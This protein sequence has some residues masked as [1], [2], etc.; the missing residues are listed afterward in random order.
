MSVMPERNRPATN[1]DLIRRYRLE[2]LKTDRKK[3][4]TIIAANENQYAIIKAYV[5]DVTKYKNQE[6]FQTTWFFD[7]V[8]T[9]E[10]EPFVSMDEPQHNIGDLY[11]DRLTGN[12]YILNYD[13]DNDEYSWGSIN[14]DSLKNSLS[15]ANSDVDTSDNKR[16][17]F[18]VQPEPLYEAGDIWMDGNTIMRCKCTR[19]DGEFNTLDWTEQS[20]YSDEY[21][22]VGVKAELDSF[23]GEVR[24][25]YATQAQLRTTKESIEG[26]VED[27]TNRVTELENSTFE[28]EITNRVE[29]IQTSTYTKTE[30]QQIISSEGFTD[31]HG[32]IINVTAIK[33]TEAKFDKDGMT[34]SKTGGLTTS[35]INNAGF[36]VN[37]AANNEEILF[38]GY[39]EDDRYGQTYQNDSAVY[40]HN[41]IASGFAN[42]GKYGRFEEY[43][44]TNN[45]V[46]VGFFITGG[47]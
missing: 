3:I 11:Y 38:A 47:E 37:N 24:E 7:G 21:V 4:S 45:N 29:Q 5:Q 33:S 16:R 27:V 10:N 39:I 9:L 13:S 36:K 31:E 41:L 8:P 35:N 22:L 14:D 1:E 6:D 32:N 12:I 19:T 44:D 46:G 17:I 30:V 26:T 25:T 42:V 18:Y 15:L 43:T 28:E 40:T 34:Y 20:N 2:D 23:K